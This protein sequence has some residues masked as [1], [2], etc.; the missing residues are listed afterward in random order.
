M[1]EKIEKIEVAAKKTWKVV[2][3]WVGG[4]TALIGLFASLAGGVTWMVNHR[5]HTLE[6][7]AKMALAET[8]T[9]QRQYEAAQ[10]T[11]QEILKDDPLDRDALDGELKN[12]MIKV[13]NFSVDVPEGKDEGEVAAAALDELLP[14]LTSG[15]A[16]A[17]SGSVA[18]IQAHLG[19][20]HFLNA[21]MTDREDDSVAMKD[22]RD[23]LSTDP[24]NVYANAMVGN[25]MLQSYGDFKEAVEHL[26]TA[27]RTGRARPLVRQFQV[28]GLV[29]LDQ[30]GA[31][32]ELMRVADEMRKGGEELDPGERSRIASWL[33]A[34]GV[35]SQPELVEALGAVPNDEAWQTY[36]WLVAG[37]SS[38]SKADKDLHG[39]FIHANLLELAGR[40]DAALSAYRQM[41]NELRDQSGTFRNQVV[42][43]IRRLSQAS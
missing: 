40:R 39:Q 23:A 34:L 13:E 10:N 7:R 20:A 5:R 31:R 27:V 28:G 2:I 24:T 38:E 35:T 30:P 21:K 36:V 42:A 1:E 11:Y 8:E 14:V 41:E 17:K 22:W 9:T 4:I 29:Y 3:A 18:D 6:Y 32:A 26:H 43:S 33:F 25:W 12:A 15:L 16:R 37:P 19:W